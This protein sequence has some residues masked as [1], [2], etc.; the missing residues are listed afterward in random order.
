MEF[1]ATCP[2][3]F[4]QLLAGELR[5]L[6]L[7]QVRPLRGQV[8]F[9]GELDKAYT[10]CLWSRLASR[11]VL[12]L[13]RVDASD[14]DTLYENISEIDWE[15]HLFRASTIAVD[16]KGTNDNL[17]NTQFIAMRTKDA[18]SDRMQQKSGWR[19]QVDVANPDLKI[20]VRLNKNRA[21]IGLDLTGDSLFRRGYELGKSRVKT[22]I[23]LR[24]DYAAALLATAGWYKGVRHDSPS[25]VVPF[26]GAGTIL[27]E[28]ASQVQDRAPGLMRSRWGF[29]GWAGSDDDLW[30][31]ILDE[32]DDRAEA[33]ATK[34]C[35]IVA[36][37]IR[38]NF[39]SY[40]T[41]TL[42]AAGLAADVHYVDDPFAHQAFSRAIKHLPSTPYC[43]SNTSF[44]G[45]EE[46][47]LEAQSL[48]VLS[49]VRP[50]LKDGVSMAALASDGVI[51]TALGAEPEEHSRIFVGSANATL[52]KYTLEGEFEPNIV[53]IR[54]EIHVPCLMDTTD[55]FASRLSKV[56]KPRRKWAEREFVSCFRIYDQDLPD[57]A[58]S[59]DMYTSVNGKVK[60]LVMNEYQ[61]PKTIDEEV[62]RKRLLD[63]LA[64][65]PKVLD[66]K[67][68]NTH[69]RVRSH[70]KGGSQYSNGIKSA[71]APKYDSRNNR[72]PSKRD[73]GPILPAGSHL[74]DENGLTFEVNFEGRLD[75][76]LFLDHRD[77]RNMLR[78]MMKQTKGSM[79]FLNLFA[80]TGTATCYAADGGA[81][82]TT[83]VD[84]S[85]PYLEWAKRNMQRN[86]FDG[87]EHEYV[88]T[89]VL[90]W[91]NDQRHTKNRWDLIFCDPPTFSNS[92]SMRSKSF[93]VQRD[94]VELLIDISRLL[95]RAGTCVFSCNLR[96]FKPDTEALAR[97]GVTIEDI[98]AE[99]I[100]EDFKRNPKIHHC[101]IV[102]RVPVPKY[103]G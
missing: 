39:K 10:A 82:Y 66:V 90:Q 72:R 23:P 86:G 21:T 30:N 3:G 35:H 18:I 25:L 8:S 59:I 27:A 38:P 63:T 77:T 11:V 73:R 29:M 62:A 51:D 96:N 71:P 60:W 102:K 4:E 15:D 81:K 54:N 16:A 61:A 46:A 50:E 53:T 7:T 68:E 56:W 70:S 58:V 37:D 6:G 5:G 43:V 34:L 99:T 26:A 33:S 14:S 84:L 2:G 93:D 47:A 9:E 75:T 100:P 57:Y 101:Y 49:S 97:A 12:V 69:L 91:V 76:G 22:I 98:T 13:A 92:S 41:Q 31:K 87:E 55:Q 79:R 80:Y 67:P 88:Q 42:R 103:K 78:E 94:H 48:S 83:T 44:V 85:R 19:V 32:A 28:A 40:C 45:A 17:R 52:R 20:V 89:D 65:A 95:T 24:P 36:S 74:V 1:F 64:V